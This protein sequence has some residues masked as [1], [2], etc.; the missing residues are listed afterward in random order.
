MRRVFIWLIGRAILFVLVCLVVLGGAGVAVYFSGTEVPLVA[1][2]APVRYQNWNKTRDLTGEVD[3]KSSLVREDG[4][5]HVTVDLALPETVVRVRDFLDGG[6]TEVLAC[7]SQ[8]LYLHK[9]QQAKIAVDKP[10]IWMGGNVD[11]EL[12]GIVSARD[13]W[14]VAIL[15]ETGHDR[16]TL[17]ARVK[18]LKLANVPPPMVQTLRD[19]LPTISYTREQVL[20]L[21]ANSLPEDLAQLLKTHRDALDLAF[22]DITPKKEGRAVTLDAT[23]SVN[24]A[25]AFDLLREKVV[26]EG[27]ARLTSAA[28]VLGPNRANA[29]ILDKLQEFTDSLNLDEGAKQLL[30]SI[31]DGKNPEQ[32]LQDTLAAFSDCQV[33]F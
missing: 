25:A 6:K 13:D 10:N 33:T 22:E 14:P 3:Y 8:K 19:G 31:E 12:D 9:L 7:G 20:D 32:I 15:I 30:K 16:T 4:R 5:I 23:F 28:G 11:M 29:Q 27:A 24:E 21:A 17:W 26:A 2:V 1:D 18:S